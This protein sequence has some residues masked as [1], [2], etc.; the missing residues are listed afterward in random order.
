ME[1]AHDLGG[2]D[3]FGPVVTLDGELTHHEPWELRAQGTALFA[4]R[5][6][7]RQW[8]ERLDPVTYL[9][10]SYYVRW[11]RAAEL[12][13][14]TQGVVSAE[15]LERWRRHFEADPDAVPPA[16]VDAEVRAKIDRMMTTTT[17]MR[18]MGAPEFEVGARVVVKRWHD[19]EHHHRCPRYAR[20]VA[21]TVERV[22]GEERVPG[23]EDHWAPTYTVAFASTDLWGAG[24]EQPF[25]VTVDLCEHY[26]EATS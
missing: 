2:L 24:G 21:G 3:G 14:V 23:A 5:G 20:G 16:V 4:T 18:P 11:L 13:A 9:T 8:I 19:P 7:M 10:S 12:G 22:C 25:T 17:R 6:G 1:G 26:L 15:D